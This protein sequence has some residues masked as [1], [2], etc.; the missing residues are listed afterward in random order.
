MATLIQIIA[1]LYKI[2]HGI[3]DGNFV[4]SKQ[5]EENHGNCHRVLQ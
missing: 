3:H 4:Y 1:K 5:L 2:F